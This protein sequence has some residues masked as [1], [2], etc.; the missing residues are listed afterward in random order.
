MKGRGR[1]KQKTAVRREQIANAALAIVAA[2]GL[3]A[4]SMTALARRVGLAPSA[5][6]RHFP[7]KDAVLA[8]ALERF[9]DAV[10]KNVRTVCDETPKSLERLH[11]LLV[12]QA[13]LIRDNAT[14]MP[15][16]AFA[17]DASARGR[18]LAASVLGEFLA[19]MTEIVR[20]GQSV[21]EIRR[22]VSAGTVALMVFGIL[23]P[24]ALV[25]HLRRGQ[26]D[27]ARHVEEGW[28]TLRRGI[29]QE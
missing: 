19:A 8:A 4:L 2:G 9:R 20:E 22:D 10:L 27:V 12:R 15:R 7:N 13:R 25:W 6:Y 23:Q 29:Q 14:I 1:P 24:A 17:E 3:R 28:Q 16:M 5:I 26:F 18:D 21:G 11:R